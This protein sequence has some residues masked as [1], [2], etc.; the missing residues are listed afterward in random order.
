MKETCT[1]KLYFYFILC[2][3]MLVFLNCYSTL[4]TA[5]T[6][7]GFGFT[8]GVYRY[9]FLRHWYNRWEDHYFLI[10]TPSFGRTAQKNRTGLE[11]RLKLLTDAIDKDGESPFWWV[12]EELKIQAHKN[13]YL[14]WA[15]LFEF[16]LYYPGSF[17]LI[18]SKDLNKIFTPYAQYKLLSGSY[19][20]EDRD[21]KSGLLSTLN[22]GTEIN[23]TRNISVL[24]EVEKFLT[25]RWLNDREMTRYSLGVNLHFPL[26]KNK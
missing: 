3:I 10:L 21:Y 26:R 11:V 18:I 25:Q 19:L 15:L 1:T 23:L 7:D 16:W 8:T 6:R 17:S 14:D 22:F 4:Q 2:I 13:K 20:L 9:E 5:K 24:L 12:S